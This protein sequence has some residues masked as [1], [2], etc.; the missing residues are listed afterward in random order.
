MLQSNSHNTDGTILMLCF[1]ENELRIICSVYLC[2]SRNH[3]N[4]N[5]IKKDLNLHT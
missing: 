4:L 2:E 3:I 5:F 1:E